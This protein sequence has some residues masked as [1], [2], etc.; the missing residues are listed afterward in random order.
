MTATMTRPRVSRAN[1]AGVNQGRYRCHYCPTVE[2]TFTTIEAHAKREH[3]GYAWIEG[4]LEQTGIRENAG[5]GRY[6]TPPSVEVSGAHS[7]ASPSGVGSASSHDQEL[8]SDDAREPYRP[9]KVKR[10]RARTSR[11]MPGQTPPAFVEGPKP[12]PEE[13]RRAQKLIER[14][15]R[16]AKAATP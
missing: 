9:Q 4:V 14:A 2:G 16:A 11:P 3:G 7:E 6:Q 13:R 12:T 15:K 5:D 10:S 1:A 8:P